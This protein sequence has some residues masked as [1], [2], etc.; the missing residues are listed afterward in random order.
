MVK[1]VFVGLPAISGGRAMLRGPDPLSA[2]TAEQPGRL[3]V[4]P[5]EFA[6]LSGLS[7]ATVHRY[8]RSGKIAFIQPIG[9]SG[10]ILIPIDALSAEVKEEQIAMNVAAESPE[11]EAPKLSGPS[12]KWARKR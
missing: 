8:R 2:T 7:L 3:F 4:A 10:R 1:V 12:P 9:Q 5:Q 6:R 11:Q